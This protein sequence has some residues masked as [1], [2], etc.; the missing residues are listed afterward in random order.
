MKKTFI[1]I[2]S[3]M[4]IF[5][6]CSKPI[7]RENGEKLSIY[8]TIFPQYD[9]ARQIA[10]DRGDVK[11]LLPPGAESHCYEPSPAEIVEISKADVFIYTGK[12]MEPWAEK[13]ISSFKD[14]VTVIDISDAVELKFD[15]H[16]GKN[17]PHIWTS[18]KNAA[19]IVKFIADKLCEAD[20]KNKEYYLSN[21][22]EYIKE[23]ELLDK[24]FREAVD[25]GKRKKIIFGGRFA[26][27]Y[28]TDEYNLSYDAA[29]DSC[30]EESEPSAKS[31]ARLSDCVKKEN[32]PVVYYEELSDG[33]TAKTICEET[34]AKPLV[35]HSC[36]NISKD[37][38]EN[39]ITYAE[40]MKTNLKN[41]KEG[42]N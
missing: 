35:F 17:N 6:G 15:K 23:L 39:N 24:S 12:E 13:I 14:K 37:D 11:M 20:E 19:L 7:K 1:F 9:F 5:S 36:H 29:Y 10:G 42:L 33:K 3:V 30:S 31:V 22:S 34:G 27:E 16:E 26:L 21:S 4:V 2:L 8:A 28:F 18:P 41:L 25:S 32:I 38:F 40:I